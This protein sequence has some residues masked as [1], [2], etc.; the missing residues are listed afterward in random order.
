M[1]WDGGGLRNHITTLVGHVRAF[2]FYLN[3]IDD[4]GK[5]LS[6]QKE[7][8]AHVGKGRLSPG[9]ERSSDLVLDGC[10]EMCLSMGVSSRRGGRQ[11]IMTHSHSA[12]RSWLR[13]HFLGETSPDPPLGQIL[14]PQVVVPTLHFPFHNTQHCYCHVLLNGLFRSLHAGSVHAGV[15]SVLV[16]SGYPVPTRDQLAGNT[17]SKWVN[18]ILGGME[19]IRGTSPSASSPWL[20]LPVSPSSPPLST[21]FY[22]PKA[23]LQNPCPGACIW[24][25]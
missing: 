18:G 20:L 11:R 17:Q 3:S 9:A 19:F 23:E 24:R 7:V 22:C 6:E 4:S 25:K 2:D 12:L 21:S 1:I 15:G 14:H 13:C 16:A 8:L 5:G 10:Q